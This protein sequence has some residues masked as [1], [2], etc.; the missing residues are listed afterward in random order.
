M[1]AYCVSFDLAAAEEGGANDAT[2]KE[3][4]ENMVVAER[5]A[6]ERG[7]TRLCSLSAF[8]VH[9]PFS[10][11]RAKRRFDRRFVVLPQTKKRRI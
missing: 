1:I 6:S 5:A 3:A 4:T 9:A 10:I 11:P 2:N 8:C 7:R